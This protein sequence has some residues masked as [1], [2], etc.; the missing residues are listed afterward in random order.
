M[1]MLA[2]LYA[3]SIAPFMLSLLHLWVP[4]PSVVHCCSVHGCATCLAPA[5]AGL[6]VFPGP[7]V[8]AALRVASVAIP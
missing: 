2:Q 3:C 8:T 7:S 4:G 1:H 6:L 5:E